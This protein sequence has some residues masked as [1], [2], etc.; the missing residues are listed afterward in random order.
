[1]ARG[2]EQEPLIPPSSNPSA[3]TGS[4]PGPTRRPGMGGPLRTLLSRLYQRRLIVVGYGLGIATSSLLVYAA[5]ISKPYTF[6]DGTVVSAAQINANFD[7]LVSEV[8]SKDSRISSLEAVAWLKGSSGFY[9]NE[10]KVGVGVS[11]PAARFEVGGGVK[12]G[13]DATTC[14]SAMAGTLRWTGTQFQGCDGTTWVQVAVQS[15]GTGQTENE[16]ALSCKGIK[17]AN[18]SAASGI[19]WIDTDGASGPIPAV[20]TYCDMTTDGGGWTL[21]GYSY[22]GSTSTSTSNRNMPSLRCGGGVFSAGTRGASAAAINATALVKNSTEIAFTSTIDGSMV[23]TGGLAA[24][25]TGMKF[26]IPDPAAVTF[27]NHSY[28]GPNFNTSTTGVGA[29]VAVTV[30][31]IVGSTAT[32]SRYTL[33]N[34]LGLSWGDSYPTGYGAGDSTSCLNENLGPMISSIHSGSTSNSY[35][36]S[37]TECDVVAGSVEYVYR[38]NYTATAV[39]TTGSS[40]IWLR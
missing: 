34:V 30:K 19:Y 23:F 35:G 31:G 5:V 13:N 20:Q 28:R 39:S 33:K 32:Y 4:G 36:Q 22:A 16:A 12:I 15:S 17:T 6:T 24:Y 26:S 7:T 3:P 10:T 37:T 27:V 25:S 29:C 40:A 14:S 8:N 1:M 11:A 18:A 38:G 9:T 2:P 21:V